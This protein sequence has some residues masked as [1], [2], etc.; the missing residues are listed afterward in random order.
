LFA[1]TLERLYSE[2]HASG[3]LKLE[4]YNALGRVQ[5][6]IEAAVE[7]GSESE[8]RAARSAEQT[9]TEFELLGV[10]LLG[11]ILLIILA[12]ISIRRRSQ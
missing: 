6:S 11:V 4:H 10:G 5:G 2:Y 12:V 7:R 8:Q 3:H 1:F 9:R